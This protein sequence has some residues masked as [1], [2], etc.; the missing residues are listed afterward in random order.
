MTFKT[1][2]KANS[3]RDEVRTTITVSWKTKRELKSLG[4]CGE[5]EESIIKRLMFKKKTG[6]TDDE[7][8]TTKEIGR[9][10]G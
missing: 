4:V 10:L 6:S 9:V 7:S 5:S 2:K 3:Q 8:E 1:R